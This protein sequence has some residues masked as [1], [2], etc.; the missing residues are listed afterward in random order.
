MKNL[1]GKPDIVFPSKKIAI[2]VHGCFWHRHAG[3]NYA[4]VPKSR[5]EFWQ[6][7]FSRNVR[8]DFDVQNR[9]IESGWKVIIIWE[10]ETKSS[11]ILDKTLD[12]KIFKIF[13]KDFPKLLF[14]H[15]V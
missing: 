10:C 14:H 6:N 5:T 1:P 2:F 7:K 4:Y 13:R 15:F 12:D 3:C 8:N 9:L 11:S